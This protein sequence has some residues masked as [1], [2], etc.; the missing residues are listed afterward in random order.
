[1]KIYILLT[2]YDKKSKISTQGNRE[3]RS[4]V[5]ENKYIAN[6]P[7]VTIDSVIL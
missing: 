5:I 3:K 6:I 4:N 1:M 7:V 2:W